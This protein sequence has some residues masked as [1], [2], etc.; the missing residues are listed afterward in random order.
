M[1][2]ILYTI[3]CIQILFVSS[4]EKSS[5]NSCP[6]VIE[7]VNLTDFP[8][9]EFGVNEIE[10]TEDHLFINVTYGGGCENH[11]FIMI[12]HNESPVD[13]G[14]QKIHKIKYYL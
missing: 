8:M 2:K 1:Q 14:G 4:C 12:M 11:D 7:D 5:V 13:G 6:N 3:L 10:V 9:D